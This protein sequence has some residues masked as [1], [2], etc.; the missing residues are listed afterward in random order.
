[1]IFQILGFFRVPIGLVLVHIAFTYLVH[2][3]AILPWFDIPMH[4]LG[5]L[6]I[7]LSFRATFL[8][9]RD[10]GWIHEMDSTVL[11]LLVFTSV[12]TAAVLWE[13]LEF[14]YDRAFGVNVQIS[15]ANTMQDLVV[16]MAGGLTAVLYLLAAGRRSKSSP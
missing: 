10:R 7:A 14:V 13:L 8:Y 16:G 11:L 5:G 1:M 6:T 3:Y 2:I 9:L 12:A 15:L 4:Y